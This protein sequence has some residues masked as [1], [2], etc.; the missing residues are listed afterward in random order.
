[1]ADTEKNGIYYGY[2]IVFIAFVMMVLGWGTYYCFGVFFDSLSEE[3]GWTRAVTSGAFSISTPVAGFLGIV[4]GRLTDR[5]S[6]RSV[7]TVCSI[8]LGLGY[9]GAAQVN[10][11][12]QLFLVYGL[13]VGAGMSGFWTPLV[14]AVARWFVARRGLMTGIVVSGIGIGGVLVVLVVSRLIITIGWRQSYII[15]GGIVLL[16]GVVG[17]QFLKNAPSQ[18]MQSSDTPGKY[19]S[20]KDYS[21]IEALRT[22]Q[23]WMTCFA[24]FSFGLALLSINVHIVPHAMDM[25]ITAVSA[26]GVLA[27]TGGMS[28]IGRILMAGLSDRIGARIS[29][30]YCFVMMSIALFGLLLAGELWQFYLFSIVFGIGY[31][32]SS[33]LQSIISAELFG[34]GSVGAIV[35]S[36]SCSFTVGGGI[37]PILTGFIFDITRNYNPAFLTWA[38]LTSFS[39]LL[40]LV[41]KPVRNT[42]G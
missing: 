22:R 36:I 10:S 14:A 7:M 5:Y 41:L 38:G 6:S 25:G 12:W 20:D 15:V 13:L 4:A 9:I 30:V 42:R 39:I 19:Y 33:A 2:I 40:F 8:L 18:V 37:G 27:A 26:A 23:C 24:Y 17:A 1:V 32:G 21:Y 34:L 28:I 29:L 16:L 35:G 3:F 11:M 31:G